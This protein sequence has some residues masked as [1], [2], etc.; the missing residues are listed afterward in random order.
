M[1]KKEKPPLYQF[2]YHGIYDADG[3][4]SLRP[5][6][7]LQ[8]HDHEYW[9]DLAVPHYGVEAPALFDP[10]GANDPDEEDPR[11]PYYIDSRGKFKFSE[12]QIV[13]SL[14]DSWHNCGD[15]MPGDEFEYDFD[16]IPVVEC[17]LHRGPIRVIL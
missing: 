17:P 15:I 1:S 4:L 16:E 8:D 11:V 5:L 10:L 13:S 6:T 12:G 2:G 7:S 9:E 3:E 14:G